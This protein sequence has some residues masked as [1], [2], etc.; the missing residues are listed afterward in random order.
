MSV[1]I[2]LQHHDVLQQLDFY[3]SYDRVAA[4]HD[5]LQQLDFYVSYDHVAT[6]RC[7][8]ATRFMHQL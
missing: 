1:M 2:V 3:V 5:V 7:V 4:S 8:A 6:S